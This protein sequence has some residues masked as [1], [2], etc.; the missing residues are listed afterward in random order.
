[1]HLIFRYFDNIKGV[2]KKCPNPVLADFTTTV[3]F[4]NDAEIPVWQRKFQF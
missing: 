3:N 1:M 2:P 4:V